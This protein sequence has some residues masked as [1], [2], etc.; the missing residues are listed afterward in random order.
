MS[1]KDVHGS[2]GL[3]LS[4]VCCLESCELD[5][6][7]YRDGKRRQWRLWRITTDINVRFSE[8]V[9]VVLELSEDGS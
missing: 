3:L 2:A 5:T 6:L 7:S 8:S 1:K 9:G 4:P